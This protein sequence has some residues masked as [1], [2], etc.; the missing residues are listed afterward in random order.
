MRSVRKSIRTSPLCSALL[1]S[2]EIKSSLIPIDDFL[3]S[4]EKWPLL[5]ECVV[6]QWMLGESCPQGILVCI[7]HSDVREISTDAL[8]ILSQL[9]IY[10]TPEKL[11][12]LDFKN[13]EDQFV[14]SLRRRV[15]GILERHGWIDLYSNAALR[16]NRV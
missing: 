10:S 5:A 14:Q 11:K 15:K 8:K 1:S 4:D 12:N 2:K 3:G 7:D 9:D 16:R 13:L 6:R